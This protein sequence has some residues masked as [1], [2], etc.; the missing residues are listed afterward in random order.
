[1]NFDSELMGKIMGMAEAISSLKS[2]VEHS[3]N[4]ATTRFDALME[5][6]KIN[7]KSFDD[8]KDS[9]QKEFSEMKLTILKMQWVFAIFALIIAGITLPTNPVI[10]STIL[11]FISPL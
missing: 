8:F 6:V 5:D 1:M 10:A 3:R 11:K 7:K 4:D 9:F 2:S